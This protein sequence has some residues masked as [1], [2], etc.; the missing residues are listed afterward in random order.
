MKQTFVL[1]VAAFALLAG[2]SHAGTVPGQYIVVLKDGANSHAAA[3]RARKLGGDV[4]A[5]YGVALHGYAA[6]LSD[7]QLASVEADPSVQF[8]SSDG[9]A[10]VAGYV[11]TIVPQIVPN[12]I[13]RID[14]ELSSTVSGDGTGSVDVNIGVVDT[15]VDLSNPDL[16]VVGGTNCIDPKK[17]YQDDNLHGTAISGMLAAEDNGFGLVGIAPGARLWEAKSFDKHA[18]GKWSSIICGIDWVTATRTDADPTNDI[19]VANGSFR[20]FGSDDGNCGRTN[21]DPVHLA[22]CNS[23]AAGVTWVVAAG[24]D[25]QEHHPCELRRGADGDGDGRPRRQAR[26][27]WHVT[28]LEPDLLRAAA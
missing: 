21:D 17:S 12:Y 24:N 16:N 6:R 27:F 20:G 28:V 15:G 10:E 26:R 1:V 11:T 18:S 4:F 5:E 14:G 19:V 9:T 7:S 22:I 13:D 2:P 25:V 3:Q 8:V 23:V